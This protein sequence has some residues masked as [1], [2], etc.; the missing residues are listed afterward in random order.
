MDL[1]LLARLKRLVII[2]MFSDDDLMD[3]LVLKGGN[4]LDSIYAIAYRSSMDVDFSMEG[5]FSEEEHG[6]I[7]AK[8]RKALS[9]T[10]QAEG[11]TIFDMTF[12]VRPKKGRSA[13]L[14]DFWGGYRV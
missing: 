2:A 14:C 12:R 8:I 3:I 10:F 6:R 11:F 1:E 7:E 9:D 4:L 5:E 13:D